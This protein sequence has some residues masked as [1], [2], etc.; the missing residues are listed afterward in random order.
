[1]RLR[2]YAGQ[3]IALTLLLIASV[4]VIASSISAAQGES[5]PVQ[6]WWL[7]LVLAPVLEEFAFR[8]FLQPWMQDWLIPRAWSKYAAPLAVVGTSLVFALCHLWSQ[9]P[10][11]AAMTFFPSLALGWLR[12]R[13]CSLMHCAAVHALFNLIYLAAAPLA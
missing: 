7:L 4:G 8:G 10:V 9:P 12:V 5:I 1:M 13:G 11:W 3:R 6:R 2:P